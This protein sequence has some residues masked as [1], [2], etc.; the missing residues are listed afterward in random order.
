VFSLY[1]HMTLSFLGQMLDELSILWV[2]AL[3][4]KVMGSDTELGT[5]ERY[6]ESRIT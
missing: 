3:G 1:F 4:Y 5:I 6:K 2:L